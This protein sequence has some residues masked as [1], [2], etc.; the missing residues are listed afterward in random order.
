MTIEK[1]GHKQLNLA[2]DAAI[3]DFASSDTVAPAGPCLGQQRLVEI[4]QSALSVE[5]PR[6]HMLLIGREGTE[7]LNCLVS[8][9]EEFVS[10]KA[11]QMS[12][13]R[14][15][16]PVRGSAG[17][18]EE[19]DL[20]P[21][22]ARL[23]VNACQQLATATF[24]NELEQHAQ[25]LQQLRKDFSAL[26][27]VTDYINWL[28]DFSVLLM[29]GENTSYEYREL[30]QMMPLLLH[31]GST[32]GMAVLRDPFIDAGNSLGTL[33]ADPETG[34][35]IIQAGALIQASGGFLILDGQQLIEDPLYWRLLRDILKNGLLPLHA[36]SPVTPSQSGGSLPLRGNIRLTCRVVVLCDPNVFEQLQGLEPDLEQ[37]FPCITEFESELARNDD[38]SHAIARIISALLKQYACLPLNAQAMATMVDLAARLTGTQHRLTLSRTYLTDIL[39]DASQLAN[40]QAAKVIE[41]S[42]IQKAIEHRRQRLMIDRRDSMQAILDGETQIELTGQV[43]GQVNSLTV[44]GAG[45]QSYPEPS[46]ITATVRPGD[47]AVVDIEREVNLGGSI[48]SKGVLIL[49]S[50]LASRYSRHTP[51]SL[52]ASVVFEQSYAYVDG[53]SASAAE[54]LAILSALAEIPLAQNLALTGSI[55]Q[56]GQIL[57]I[58]DVNQKIEG[59]YR[60][61]QAHGGVDGA[62]VVIPSTN[63]RDLMLE[64][65]VVEAVRDGRFDIHTVTTIDDV[66]KL[67]TGMEAGTE[68][69]DHEFPAGTFN[70]LVHESLKQFSE[71]KKHEHKDD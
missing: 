8:V 18:Y 35:K 40:R 31:A 68:D 55:D 2:T 13:D 41:S 54:M 69:K 71:E 60:L 36:I 47:G 65:D 16:L 37:V 27:A 57:C 9:L 39:R 45:V 33:S 38:N 23:L 20:Q 19:A 62:G 4:L 28:D 12:P 51:L 3:F 61:C 63:L 32:E 56:R 59:F 7:R 22:H 50:L 64:E 15:L 70:A 58:G 52:V 10:A 49:T 34:R 44:I 67:F 30:Q 6:S 21:G 48:H 1:L 66:I 11:G 5:G 24:T 17:L 29:A 53:D 14:V 43:V 42:H 25:I 26:P 46:R